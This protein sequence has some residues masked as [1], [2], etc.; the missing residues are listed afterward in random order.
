MSVGQGVLTGDLSY[1]GVG[2]EITYGTYVTGTAALNFLSASFKAKKETKILEEIQTKRTNSHSI[3]MGKIVTGDL[4]TYYSPRNLACNYFLQNAFGGGPVTS[5]TATGDT[6][7]AVSFSHQVDVANFAATYSS[8]S[9]NMRKGE[10]TNGKV[11]EY[12]GIRVNDLTLS[13]KIDDALSMKLSMVARDV[14]I[15]GNDVAGSLTSTESQMPLSFVNGRFSVETSET[16]L[17]TTSYWNVSAF[18]FKL[19]NNLKSDAASRRIGSDV[20]SVLPAGLAQ[21]DLK[22]TVRFDTTTAFDAMMAGTRLAAEFMFEGPTMTGSKLRES[23]KITLPY[24]LVSDAG[25]PEI[26]GPNDPL[27]SEIVF[28]VLRDGT[29]TT[30]YAVRAT[31]INDVSSYA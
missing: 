21:F 18:E 22:A 4:E 2:R 10:V 9:I 28:A 1:I 12:S 15:T 11:F 26:K 19:S 24:V 20:L 5:A 3:Q 31:V 14:T 13:A 7:G 17:T 27:T 30:G 6:A 25:D 8:L 23:I 16:A 29:T